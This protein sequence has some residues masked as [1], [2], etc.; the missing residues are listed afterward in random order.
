MPTPA[1]GRINNGNFNVVTGAPLPD[2]PFYNTSAIRFAAI[3][4]GLS[5]TAGYSETILGNNINTTP[6]QFAAVDSQRQFALFNYL[7]ILLTFPASYFLPPSTYRSPLCHPDRVVGRPGP[8]MV[9]RQLHH[10]VV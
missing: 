7:E 5:N 8:R 1:P 6:G 4:D 9:A 2:G 10:G 3:T